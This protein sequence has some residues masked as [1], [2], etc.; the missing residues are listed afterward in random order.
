MRDTIIV[1][2]SVIDGM[3]IQSVDGWW[4]ALIVGACLGGFIAVIDDI[5]ELNK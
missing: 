5:L 1:T 2:I 4:V 3:V